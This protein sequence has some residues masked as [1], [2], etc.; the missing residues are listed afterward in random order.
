MRQLGALALE[1]QDGLTIGIQE[2]WTGTDP[3]LA[4]LSE[5]GEIGRLGLDF[6]VVAATAVDKLR[7]KQPVKRLVLTGLSDDAT[8]V[9]TRL[10]KSTDLIMQG[11]KLSAKGWQR[12]ADIAEGTEWL[13][14]AVS[15]D[16]DDAKLTAVTKIDSLKSLYLQTTQV[17]SAG[18]GQLASLDHLE[19]LW[20]NEDA[21]IGGSGYANLADCQ[22]LKKLSL[23]NMPINAAA[24]QGLAKLTQLR[25]LRVSPEGFPAQGLKPADF[26]PLKDL[27]GLEAL[28]FAINPI[29]TPTTLWR[30]PLSRLPPRC[31]R[32]RAYR[33]A[34][35]TWTPTVWRRS[36]AS[37]LE[38][39][40]VAP[41]KLNDEIL[42][43]LG[44]LT[45]LKQLRLSGRGP[46][47]Q[48]A[49]RKIGAR[50]RWSTCRSWPAA[51][52]TRESQNWPVWN[53]WKLLSLEKAESPVRA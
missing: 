9:L 38:E 24:L 37:H 41:I 19:E 7:F 44:Q 22:S 15:T 42:T 4:L 2:G 21:E 27:T 3:D 36:P 10:P 26:G 30:M 16:F 34:I 53:G 35:S 18:L 49:W 43:R 5:V 51:P 20:L 6:S 40:S 33:S 46:V 23:F 13:M 28:N 29:Q 45:D 25:D 31:R 8:A 47:G 12:L 11:D 32:A 17:T 48:S 14:I 52:T 50:N 39:L 1:E